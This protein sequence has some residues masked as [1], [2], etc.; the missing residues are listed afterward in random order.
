MDAIEPTTPPGTVLA[1]TVTTATTTSNTLTSVF[2]GTSS[3]YAKQE[4]AHLA[5]AVAVDVRTVVIA[6]PVENS[7]TSEEQQR[8]KNVEKRKQTNV[9]CVAGLF[10]LVLTAVVLAVL[11]TRR[12]TDQDVSSSIENDGESAEVPIVDGG[13][14]DNLPSLE[15]RRE[16]MIALLEPIYEDLEGTIQVFDKST[17]FASEDRIA[18]LEWLVKDSEVQDLLLE[19]M[20]DDDYEQQVYKVRQRYVLALLYMA[21]NGK[22]WYDQYN[23]LADIDECQWTDI[24]TQEMADDDKSYVESEYNVKGAVCNDSGQVEKLLMCKYN[25]RWTNIFVQFNSDTSRVRRPSKISSN[26]DNFFILIFLYRIDGNRLFHII[27]P[28]KTPKHLH[29][30]NTMTILCIVSGWNGM[31][32]TIPHELSLFSETIIEINFTGGSISGSLPFSI[33]RLKNLEA[34]SVSDNC[35]SGDL[36]EEM[37]PIDMPK[38]G[39]VG[40]HMNNYGV[41]ASSGNMGAFCDGKGGRIEGVVALAMDC[42]PEAFPNYD[43]TNTTN[44]ATLAEA[45]PWG[46]D[47]CFCCHPEKYECQDLSS[48]NNWTIYFV[49]DLSPDGYPMGFDTQCV[50]NEQQGWIAENCPCVINVSTEPIT[51]PFDGSCV[52]DCSQEG[53]IPSYDFGS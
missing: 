52:T 44:N 25:C 49:Y 36:P 7:E 23:F 38:L 18:A 50:S 11:L 16:D 19:G 39:I 1:A 48:G 8:M 15:E 29:R 51:N 14:Q 26:T 41:T 34:L 31:S 6:D 33:T 27:V 5:T 42:P 43:T 17:S 35:M 47:C 37:N 21:T 10:V 2:S 20:E 22:G 28:S 32:G 30:N 13:E 45:S 46:C 24:Y 4:D 9:L 53:A 40:V 12:D 3:S